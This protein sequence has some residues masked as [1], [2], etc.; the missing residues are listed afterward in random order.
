MSSRQTSNA[1][2][3]AQQTNSDSRRS[4]SD[5]RLVLIKERK[6]TELDRGDLEKYEYRAQALAWYRQLKESLLQSRARAE[7]G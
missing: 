4:K 2:A 7:P 1:K 6:G 3:P 5:L